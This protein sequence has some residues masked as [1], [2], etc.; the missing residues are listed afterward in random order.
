MKAG[1]QTESA[2]FHGPDGR[3]VRRMF[4]EIAH[5]YDFLNHFL[6]VSIDKRWRR[7]AVAKVRE[8]IPASARPIIA[9]LCSG[10]GDLALEL[11]RELAAPIVASD[12]CHP[13]LTRS[14]AKIAAAHAAHAIRIVEADAL[15][16]P[17]ADSMFSAVTNGFGLRNLEDTRAGLTEILRILEPG[18]VVVILEFSKPVNPVFRRFFDLYSLYVLPRFGALISGHKFAY[19]YLPESVRRFP[20]QPELAAIMRST[21]FVEVSYAN[22]LGGVVALHWGHKPARGVTPIR[23]L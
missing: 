20:L 19:Q 1:E 2:T 10:T 7:A 18:G 22:L 9:D 14:N 12:F 11:S 21:G 8:L 3:A 4:E 6:S 16:L 17:F 23:T 5:R 15:S 13:M